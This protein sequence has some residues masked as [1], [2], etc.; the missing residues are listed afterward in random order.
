[1][2]GR[3]GSGLGTEAICLPSSMCKVRTGIQAPSQAGRIHLL[4]KRRLDHSSVTPRKG[5]WQ[6]VW[7]A[8]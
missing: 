8:G 1:M 2:F 6:E 3:R 4:V 7:G 5:L